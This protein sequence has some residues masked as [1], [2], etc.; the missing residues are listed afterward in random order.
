[1]DRGTAIGV[2]THAQI[3]NA[4]HQYQTVTDRRQPVPDA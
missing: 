4:A 3:L 2:E 1:V